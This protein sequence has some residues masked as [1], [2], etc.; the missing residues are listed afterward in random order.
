MTKKSKTNKRVHY[1]FKKRHMND[2]EED[3]KF[4]RH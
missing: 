4:L 3:L 1:E 2:K